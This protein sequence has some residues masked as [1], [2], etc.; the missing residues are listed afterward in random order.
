[1]F[2]YQEKK[3]KDIR[4][5]ASDLIQYDVETNLPLFLHKDRGDIENI[6]VVGAWQGDEVRAFLK[7]PN[8]HIYCFEANPKT[9]KILD[10]LYKKESRVHCYNYACSDIDGT[11]IFHETN[12]DGNG[13]L[14]EVGDHPA[15]KAAGSFEVKTIRLDSLPEL[16]DKRI[17]LLQIDVQGAELSVLKGADYILNSAAA[18]LIEVNAQGGSYK[19]AATYSEIDNVI[20]QYGFNNVAQGLDQTGIEGNALY[21]KTEQGDV[22]DRNEVEQRI[23]TILAPEIKK[24]EIYHNPVFKIIHR[25]TPQAIR[26]KLKKII[27]FN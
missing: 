4:F 23:E 2:E 25:V 7:F 10:E 9:F 13:S 27:R 1:M 26:T 17:D 12:I 11:A 15:A 8:T 3:Y 14:L 16:K 5:N 18:L 19:G 20:K 22:F 24:R 6:V 21:M